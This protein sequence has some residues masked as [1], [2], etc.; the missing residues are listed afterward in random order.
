MLCSAWIVL[1]SFT[2]P[3]TFAR[4][5]TKV[6]FEVRSCNFA[7]LGFSF[8]IPVL[9][10]ISPKE[11]LKSRVVRTFSTSVS[12]MAAAAGSKFPS[13]TLF[14]NTPGGAVKSEELFAS[15]KS[16]IFGVPG[17][18]TPGC[19]KT[20]LPGYVANA[21]KFKAKGVK[22]IVCV[23]VN[24]PFVMVSGDARQPAQLTINL[25]AANFVRDSRVQQS[26]QHRVAA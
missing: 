3:S 7:D 8:D 12:K 18:F 14:E 11:M 10:T 24:D 26:I 1:T 15:G 9:C 2:N 5:K 4:A 20:H 22:E 13:V 19:T 17:A 6:E 23:S 16:I 25:T 21:E